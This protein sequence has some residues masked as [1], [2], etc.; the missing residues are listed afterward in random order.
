MLGIGR[1]GRENL[2]SVPVLRKTGAHLA[3]IA[4]A[5]GGDSQIAG[6]AGEKL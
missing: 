4:D 1:S 3:E 2:A 6:I 5:A